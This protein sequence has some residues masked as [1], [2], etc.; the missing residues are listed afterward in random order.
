MLDLMLTRTPETEK[1][2]MD[3][4]QRLIAV[5][6]QDFLSM[7]ERGVLPIDAANW[8]QKKAP[9]LRK[10]SLRQYK[11]ALIHLFETRAEDDS[12]ACPEQRLEYRRGI[13]MLGNISGKLCLDK[14]KLP[15]RTSANK[16]KR[17]RTEDILTLEKEMYDSKSSVWRRRAFLW[18][19]SGMACGLRPSEWEATELIEAPGENLL[20]VRAKNAKN[21]N[22][23]AGAESRE[24]QVSLSILA[25]FV[26]LHLSEIHAFMDGGGKF[27]SYYDNAR[28]E[29]SK[30]VRRI[31]PNHPKKHYSLYSGRHQF[32]ANLKKAE[33]S[34]SV[35]AQLMGHSSTRTAVAHYGRK[36]SGKSH[37]APKGI[38]R[39]EALA[40][41]PA[42]TSGQ[43]RTKIKKPRSL[44]L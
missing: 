2:Y 7:P 41:P 16:I 12:A 11:S 8:L 19:L 1:S 14:K 32:C 29:L 37:L 28:T 21:T 39:P 35:I 25:Q 40:Q 17:I 5:I 23:R 43:Q 38:A 27:K 24:I 33:M 3:R 30:T 44:S 9:E 36:V 20:I 31:W 10:A 26:R 4:A 34:L 13:E 15:K 22:G 18:L 42:Q 6:A